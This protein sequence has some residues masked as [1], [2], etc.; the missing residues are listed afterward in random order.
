MTQSGFYL[1]QIEVGPMENFAYLLG[2][3]ATHQVILV[4][5]AWEVDRLIKAAE[6]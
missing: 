5:P 4:D 2:D 3:L 6:A 1:K